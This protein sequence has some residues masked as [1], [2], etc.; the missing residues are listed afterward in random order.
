M[1]LSSKFESISCE[2]FIIGLTGYADAGGVVSYS[3]NYLARKLKCN[4]ITIISGDPFLDYTINRPLVAIS[5]GIARAFQRI[6]YHV[7]LSNDGRTLMI[8]GPEPNLKWK[9][10]INM[11][12]KLANLSKAKLICTLGGFI[13]NVGEPKVSYVIPSESLK[14]SLKIDNLSPIEYRGPS[15]IYSLMVIKARE[16]NLQALSLWVHV[17]YINHVLLPQ[18][19]SIDYW[20]SFELLSTVNKVLNL[21]L[22]L[23]E[24]EE[25]CRKFKNRLEVARYIGEQ[26]LPREVSEQ[27]SKYI[28]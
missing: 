8:V 25:Q 19:G 5:N 1:A 10:F 3:T 6:N 21:N 13:D 24:A 4:R 16:R 22:D 20:S 12:F 28:F 18:L 15:S 26:G 14:E 23:K 17:P 2:V 7:L 11:I 27:P 9:S